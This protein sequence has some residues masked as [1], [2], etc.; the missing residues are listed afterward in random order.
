MKPKMLTIWAVAAAAASLA[1]PAQAGTYSFAAALTGAAEAPP[2]T[3]GASGSAFVTFDDVAFSVAVTEI[4]IGLSG[5][6]AT[7]SHIHCCTSVAGTGTSPVVLG[8]TS[9][10]NVTTGFYTNT[11]TLAPASFATLL[12]GTQAGQA[13]VNIHNAANPS[14]EI[15]GFLISTAVPEPSTYAMMIAGLAGLGLWSR[16]RQA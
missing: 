9:F 7:A 4:F 12:T 6:P 2:V 11:F 14:G 13:Y 15:R 8:F 16:R 10:P 5:G 3:T 1:L